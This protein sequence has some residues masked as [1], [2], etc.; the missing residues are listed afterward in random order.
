MCLELKRYEKKTFTIK[1]DAEPEDL[2]M[3]RFRTDEKYWEAVNKG[4]VEVYEIQ[5]ARY[6]K[7][8]SFSG[9]HE[10]GTN[11]SGGISKAMCSL[12]VVYGFAPYL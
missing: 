1:E 6:A 7:I 4:V 2:V 3:G 12:S 10:S 9:T 11:S 5:G 8:K